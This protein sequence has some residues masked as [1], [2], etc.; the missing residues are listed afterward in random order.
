MSRTF[1]LAQLWAS[2][3]GIV[4]AMLVAYPVMRAKGHVSFAQWVVTVA[5]V[6]L[7]AVTAQLLLR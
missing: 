6:A 7:I 1:G 3:I 5:V 2:A 4:L